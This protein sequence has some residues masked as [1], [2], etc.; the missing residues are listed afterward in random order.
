MVGGATSG[1]AGTGSSPSAASAGW[2]WS[3]PNTPPMAAPAA[4]SSAAWG[5]GRVR[6]PMPS[7]IGGG[8]GNA[9]GPAGSPPSGL[10]SK[11]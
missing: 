8:G 9:G 10:V 4:T 2:R 6:R 11:T 7:V 3:S 1:P 5:P